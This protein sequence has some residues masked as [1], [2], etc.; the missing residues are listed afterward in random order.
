MFMSSCM[1]A[2]KE[3]IECNLQKHHN[4]CIYKLEGWKYCHSHHVLVLLPWVYD[5]LLHALVSSDHLKLYSGHASGC[6][7]WS[8]TKFQ[9]SAVLH[10]V[11]TCLLLECMVKVSLSRVNTSISP[12]FCS[13]RRQHFWEENEY[14]NRL[15]QRWRR[16]YLITMRIIFDCVKLDFL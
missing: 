1:D 5:C 14:F 10:H 12:I 4:G 11:Y 8:L 7:L 9:P 6:S 13:A 3:I 16:V 15:N 2:K